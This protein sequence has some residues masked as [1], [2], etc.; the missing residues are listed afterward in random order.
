MT[1]KHPNPTSL[2]E[3]AAKVEAATGPDRE[4]DLAIGL[5]ALGWEWV[6]NPFDSNP[7]LDF[8]APNH[9][10][11]RRGDEPPESVPSPTG[12]IDAALRLQPEGSHFYLEDR[13]L[14]DTRETRILCRAAFF[15]PRVMDNSVH[16]GSA[17]AATPALALT[18]AALKARAHAD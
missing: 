2:L 4:L 3:L 5:A 1:D 7:I 13:Y 11:W 16:L 9:V 14:T 12:S 10:G 6:D 17:K 15:E 8:G 18:A